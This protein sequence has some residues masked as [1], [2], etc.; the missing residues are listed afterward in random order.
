MD[1]HTG[2]VISVV[3]L[4]D[5][6]PN[7]RPRPPIEGEDPTD[8]PLFNR[9]VQGVYELGSTFK[10]FTAAQAMDLGLV[11]ANTMVNTRRPLRQSGHEIGEFRNKS[12][13]PEL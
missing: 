4:P 6:D 8:S 11:N 7:E 9:A 10:I 12:Y 5:F 3:S 13:G 1:V 2:E